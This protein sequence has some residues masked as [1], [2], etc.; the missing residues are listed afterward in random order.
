MLRRDDVEVLLAG[1][2]LEWETVE[3]VRDAIAAGKP[4]AL[5]LLGHVN[6]EEAGME[7][8]ARWLKAFVPETPV[9]FIPARDPFWSPK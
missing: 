8:C 1:E 4:K 2:S 9:E 3:Y 5:I 6:S 7:Y